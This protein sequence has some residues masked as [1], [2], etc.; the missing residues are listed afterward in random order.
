MSFTQLCPRFFQ[1]AVVTAGEGDTGAFN[2]GG[3]SNREA[4]TALPP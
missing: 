1:P 3:A 2:G 4:D